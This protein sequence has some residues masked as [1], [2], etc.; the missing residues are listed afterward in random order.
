MSQVYN[1][2]VDPMYQQYANANQMGEGNDPNSLYADALREE[3][4]KNVIETLNPDLLLEDI[5]HRIRGEKKN[6]LTHEWEPINKQKKSLISEEL[7]TNY[8]SFL[9]SFLNQ[10]TTFSNFSAGQINNIMTIVVEFLRDDL[11]DNAE[12]YEFI[13]YD[14]YGNDITD[15][16]EMT[17]IGNIIA[18]ST[19][20]VLNRAL[21][22]MESRRF[23]GILKYNESNSVGS[24][25]K[26]ISDIFKFWN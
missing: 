12:L 13:K 17:R 3:K 5:E 6:R 7:V 15:Y 21:N 8:I 24:G 16:N 10:N 2:E 19:F 23:F 22:G 9:G 20:A 4:T 18:M 14:K 25:K 26:S 11:S 1:Q